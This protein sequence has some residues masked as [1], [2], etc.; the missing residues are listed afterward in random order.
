MFSNEY[1]PSN[2]FLVVVLRRFKY[3]LSFAELYNYELCSDF[4]ESPRI[5]KPLSKLRCRNSFHKN[6]SQGCGVLDN[7]TLTLFFM[8]QSDVLIFLYQLLKG[9]LRVKTMLKW[10]KFINLEHPE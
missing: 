5:L 4:N 8:Y 3:V 7:F 2:A 6:R 9:S 10:K 1:S